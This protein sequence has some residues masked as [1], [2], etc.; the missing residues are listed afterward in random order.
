M[1]LAIMDIICIIQIS[2]NMSNTKSY[3]LEMKEDLHRELKIKAVEKDTT[4]KE[5]M[6]EALEKYLQEQKRN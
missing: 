4:L 1:S 6:L 2:D 3:Q 5:I